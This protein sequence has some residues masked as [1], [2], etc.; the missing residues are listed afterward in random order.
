MTNIYSMSA[1]KVTDPEIRAILESYGQMFSKDG[2]PQG[3]Q[4]NPLSPERLTFIRPGKGGEEDQELV[5]PAHH[6]NIMGYLLKGFTIH[7][8]HLPP[9]PRDE[10]GLK[11]M[12]ER[13]QKLKEY[14]QRQGEWEIAIRGGKTVERPKPPKGIWEIEDFTCEICQ[15]PFP[16]KAALSGHQSAHKKDKAETA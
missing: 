16:S 15:K 1:T 8:K 14:R 6:S 5:L 11:Q 13:I 12:D 7:P 2:V 3:T 4:R 9:F 10:E